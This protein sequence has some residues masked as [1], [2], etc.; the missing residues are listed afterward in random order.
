VTGTCQD[1]DLDPGWPSDLDLDLDLGLDVVGG[2]AGDLEFARR[3][4][5]VVKGESA[6]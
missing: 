4:S 3:I 2:Q 6:P 1:S 5:R